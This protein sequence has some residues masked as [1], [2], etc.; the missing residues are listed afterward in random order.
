M[1]ICSEKETAQ[2]LL[3]DFLQLVFGPTIVKVGF[4]EMGFERVNDSFI[5]M[6]TALFFQ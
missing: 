2:C 3:G 1:Q 5:E 6:N 4:V